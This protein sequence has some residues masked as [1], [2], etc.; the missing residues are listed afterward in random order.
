MDAHVWKTTWLSAFERF[1]VPCLVEMSLGIPIPDLQNWDPWGTAYT[2][3]LHSTV[4]LRVVLDLF[5]VVRDL[6]L[7]VRVFTLSFL[8][9]P[10][11]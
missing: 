5:R 2:V 8:H 10:Y 3:C 9:C 1:H 11:L 4:L 7:V 6:L